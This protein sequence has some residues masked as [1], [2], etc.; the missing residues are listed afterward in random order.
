MV[1]GQLDNFLVI[2]LVVSAIISA[3]LGDY[4]ES[5]AI[6]AI[7]VLNAVLGVIQE[8]RAEESLAALKRLASPEAQVLRDGHRVSLPARELVPGDIVFWKPAIMCRRTC[9]FWR[10]LTCASKKRH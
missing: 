5:G 9:A 3:L 1:I 8:S 2:L 4:L 6:L 10:P 7:V